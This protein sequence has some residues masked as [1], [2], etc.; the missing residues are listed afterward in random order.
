[1]S[2]MSNHVQ[3]PDIAVG[4]DQSVLSIDIRS[5]SGSTIFDF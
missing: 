1:M 3:V 5:V 4:H 2:R